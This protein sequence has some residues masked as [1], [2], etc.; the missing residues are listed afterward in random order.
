MQKVDTQKVGIV[1]AGAKP[2]IVCSA[3]I[4]GGAVAVSTPE[5]C[6]VRCSF[7]PAVFL[8]VAF[9]CIWQN[10]IALDV[11]GDATI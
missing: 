1:R 8:L 9:E 3:T 10:A 11:D 7:A 6:S 4:I 2:T 5:V